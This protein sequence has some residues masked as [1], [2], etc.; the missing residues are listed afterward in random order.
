[1]ADNAVPATK[2]FNEEQL[3]PGAERA[4]EGLKTG[5]DRASKGL[6][7]AADQVAQQAGV[8]AVCPCGSLFGQAME[9][10]LDWAVLSCLMAS[11]CT[12]TSGDVYAAYQ[13]LQQQAKLA[14]SDLKPIHSTWQVWQV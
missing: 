3:K 7:D 1:M 6:Q 13:R 11:M 14:L 12:G 10:Y 4:G 2:Q 5:A 8:H 9:K